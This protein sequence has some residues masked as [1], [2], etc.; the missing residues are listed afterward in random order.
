[1]T[2]KNDL[3]QPTTA[4]KQ[5]GHLFSEIDKGEIKIP[6]FQR[7]FVWT[8][9]QTAKL[10]DSIIRGYPIGA[11]ILW[12]TKERLRHIKNIGNFKLPEPDKTDYIYYVLDGQQ[13]ITSLYAMKAG[14]IYK[15]ENGITINY[16]DI[17]INLDVET[18]SEEDIVVI[19]KENEN[20]ISVFDVL[21]Q[22]LAILFD[23]YTNFREKIELYKSKLEG[24][25]FSTI[26]LPEYPMD[27]ACDVFTR[28]NTGGTE[29]SLFEIMVAKTYDE[30]T[31]FDLSTKFLELVRSTSG[32]KSLYDSGFDTI[33][34][35]VTIQI[36]SAILNKEVRRR[37]I[38]KTNKDKFI[39]SWDI[40][41]ESLFCCV[42]FVRS[43]IGVPV[44]QLLP[45]PAILV[46][47]SYFFAKNKCK[48]PD[49]NQAKLLKQYFYWA[50]LTWRYS[51]AAEG[52]IALDIKKMEKI[53][54]GQMPH[55]GNE[56]TSILDMDIRKTTFS[57]GNAYCKAILC[58][59]AS[60]KPRTF[61]TDSETI[62]DN[63]YLRRANSRNYHHFF[64]QSHLANQ[65]FASEDINCIANITLVDDSL[66]KYEIRAKAPKKYISRFSKENDN[67]GDTLKSHLIGYSG[68]GIFEDD[69]E[70]F[71]MERSKLIAKKLNVFLEY[72]PKN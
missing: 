35:I 70:H 22:R 4:P 51:S 13:R 69:Y 53:L 65:G 67:I 56:M 68:F 12:K 41:K 32:E 49:N 40:M 14:V 60:M 46:P 66:N 18:D 30:K 10:I 11:F 59:F 20:C 71:L 6:N 55:Y 44:S 47:I 31:E 3:L 19:D 25:N 50:A 7:D 45:Y 9:E 52:K 29:L 26:T 43:K 34:S 5:Y 27:I 36:I 23:R 62:L 15:N 24:Y 63:S 28:L 58:L 72:K 39:E 2:E 54:K 8:K 16:K 17:F 57:A 61:N 21:N 64:P 38:L 48:V 42:D 37:D 1:M 33:G